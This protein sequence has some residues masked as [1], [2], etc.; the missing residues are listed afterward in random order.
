MPNRTTIATVIGSTTCSAPAPATASTTI[1][2]SLRSRRQMVSP[3]D[4]AS[5]TRSL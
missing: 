5:A 2:P 4:R 3:F 1:L